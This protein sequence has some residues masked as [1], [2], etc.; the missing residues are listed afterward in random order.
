MREYTTEELMAMGCSE[1][2]DLRRAVSDEIKAA[3][4]AHA[5]FMIGA[6]AVLNALLAEVRRKEKIK[7]E[8]RKGRTNSV[9]L[10]ELASLLEGYEFPDDPDLSA[11]VYEA[12]AFRERVE[13]AKAERPDR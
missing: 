2:N 10:C 6:N 12:V 7:A 1:L 11:A 4:T 3:Q 5:K 8:A 13:K 9:I